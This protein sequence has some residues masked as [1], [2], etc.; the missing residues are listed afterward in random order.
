MFV[1]NI[2]CT[3]SLRASLLCNIS[4]CLY[5]ADS[6]KHSKRT[7]LLFTCNLHGKGNKNPCLLKFSPPTEGYPVTFTI[8]FYLQFK[9]QCQVYLTASNATLLWQELITACLPKLCQCQGIPGSASLLQWL[10]WNGDLKMPWS[11]RNTS[12]DAIPT[13]PAGQCFTQTAGQDAEKSVSNTN[14]CLQ[15]CLE[16]WAESGSWAVR[17]YLLSKLLCCAVRIACTERPASFII[18]SNSLR[19]LFAKFSSISLVQQV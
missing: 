2:L 9:A 11:Y 18:A 4:W 12:R 13:T 19:L 3:I 17:F 6:Y 15:Q 7:N 14:P 8:L 1:H 5:E 10:L 16:N